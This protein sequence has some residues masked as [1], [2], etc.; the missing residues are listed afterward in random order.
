MK[1]KTNL[2]HEKEGGYT[3]ALFGK[4]RVNLQTVAGSRVYVHCHLIAATQVRTV[5]YK[6][7][8][9]YADLP[10]GTIKRMQAYAKK[11]AQ[12][13]VAK[14]GWKIKKTEKMFSDEPYVVC[15]NWCGFH[16]GVN[17]EKRKN[18]KGGQNVL[19]RRKR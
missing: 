2:I 18:K 16:F 4:P 13:H 8:Y 6:F 5:T 14:K 10:K 9:V 12:D 7:E 3:M 17:E 11:L 1:I 19:G 15:G